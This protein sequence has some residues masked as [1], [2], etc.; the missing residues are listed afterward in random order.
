MSEAEVKAAIR[1]S[2]PPSVTLFNNPVGHATYDGKRSMPYGLSVGASDLIGWQSIR[3]TEDMVGKVV[4]RFVAIE[5]KSEKG[6]ATDAQSNF[7][8]QVL[9]AGG[10][11]GVARSV[12]DLEVILNAN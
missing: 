12:K 9:D 5:T 4:A 8:E 11:A 10:A 1:T 7:I 2:L 3:V 6:R